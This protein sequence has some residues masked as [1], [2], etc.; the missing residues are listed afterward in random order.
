[1]IAAG[2]ALFIVDLAR[3]FRF[4]IEGNAGNVWNAGTLEWLPSG[5]YATRSIPSV[6]SREPLWDQPGLARDVEAGHYYLPNAPTGGRE[7]IVSSP[8]EAAPQWLMRM[9]RPGWPPIVAAWFTAAFFLLLTVKWVLPACLCG[10]VA[11]GAML[12]WAWRLDPPPLAAPV[13]VGGGLALPAYMSG[14]RSQSWW[15]MVVLMLVAGSVYGCVV[16]SYLYLWTVSPQVWP[17]AD[18]L[19]EL[20]HLVVP[21]ALYAASS[22]AIGLANRAL[23]RGRSFHPGVVAAIVLFAAGFAADLYAHRALSPAQSSY[24][25]VVY[26]VLSL[27]GFFGAVS[28]ALALFAMARYAHGLLDRVR[29]VTFDNARLFW[30]YSV[31][32]SLVGLAL[33]HG[34]PRLAG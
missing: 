5:T 22:A 34:F 23:D 4:A 33:V 30:H 6:A 16:F 20:V 19:P 15:A 8:I 14:P 10:A 11:I 21:A 1:M 24:G 25:A 29:R 2:V 17:A 32:Q 9:P 31:G 26:L 27:A 12:A 13:E 28:V 18:R 3:R 7:T